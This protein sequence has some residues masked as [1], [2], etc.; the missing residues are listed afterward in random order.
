MVVN[1][2]KEIDNLIFAEQPAGQ[3]AIGIVG[4]NNPR[5][6]NALMQ[7]AIGM[8]DL[9]IRAEKKTALLAGLSDLKWTSDGTNNRRTVDDYLGQF[10]DL[11]DI[12][13]SAVM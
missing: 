4:L 12:H 11:T 5:A 13:D 1:T 7:V 8:A 6:L 3:F 9:F 10:A 2:V